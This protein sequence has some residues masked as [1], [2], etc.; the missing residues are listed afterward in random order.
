[1]YRTG[2]EPLPEAVRGKPTQVRLAT[3]PDGE[4]LVFEPLKA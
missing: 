3:G 1:V 4:R 2:E